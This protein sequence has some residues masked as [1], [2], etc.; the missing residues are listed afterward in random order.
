MGVDRWKAPRVAEAAPFHEG[1]GEAISAE[2][3]L[4][5]TRKRPEG[6]GEVTGASEADCSIATKMRGLKP[7]PCARADRR[8][9]SRLVKSSRCTGFRRR[10]PCRGRS[11]NDSWVLEDDVWK[12]IHRLHASLFAPLHRLRSREAGRARHA[13]THRAVDADDG[14]GRAE[15]VRDAPRRGRSRSEVSIATATPWWSNTDGRRSGCGTGP[16]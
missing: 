7:L 9:A 15:T 4:L 14:G 5:R 12:G 10:K 16:L 3:E 2:P 1:A 11:T 6:E 8:S 13:R